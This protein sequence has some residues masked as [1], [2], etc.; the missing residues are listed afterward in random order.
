MYLGTITKYQVQVYNLTST[1]Q[2]GLMLIYCW[3]II[4]SVSCLQDAVQGGVKS[5]P[6][7]MTRVIPSEKETIRIKKPFGLVNGILLKQACQKNY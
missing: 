2:Y 5:I 4:D 3:V 1:A 6:V 7:L